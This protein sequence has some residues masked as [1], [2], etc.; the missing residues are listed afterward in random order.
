MSETQLIPSQS[1]DL[2]W[3][4]DGFGHAQRVAK[5]FCESMLIPEHMRGKL[6]DV[7]I[8]LLM[9]KRLNEDPLVVMQ[10]IHNIKGKAGWS[11]QYVIS[12][13]NQ[14][15]IFR[16]RIRYE[17]EGA[18]DTL[19]V[20]AKA[21]LAETNEE[22]SFTCDMQ[23]AKNEGW[24][25]SPKYKSMPKVMLSYRAATF[26]VRL[27]CPEVML[28][29][30]TTTLEELE[31][32]PAEVRVVNPGAKTP[33]VRAI[34]EAARINEIPTQDEREAIEV[35]EEQQPEQQR[36][37]RPASQT[38]RDRTIAAGRTFGL[39]PKD[40]EARVQH[41]AADWTDDDLTELG[42]MIREARAAKSA[43]KPAAQADDEGA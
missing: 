9:A 42:A 11:A 32:M 22:I 2:L 7:T 18:G 25:S 6:P 33:A 21:T 4:S 36:A 34:A 28:G 29:Y 17:Y 27:N 40:L 3:S 37:P 13:A 35:G 30:S 41:S 23:M 19:A 15:G 38:D 5:L 24:T 12:R 39:S 43:P 14:S 16:G 31:T 1:A 8:A 26:L 20:T 10:N